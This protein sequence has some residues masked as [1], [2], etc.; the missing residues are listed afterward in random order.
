M[1]CL[2]NQRVVHGQNYAE[3]HSK[4]QSSQAELIEESKQPLEGDASHHA[5]SAV[6]DRPSLESR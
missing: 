2:L 3:A 4:I 5:T 6:E 1:V